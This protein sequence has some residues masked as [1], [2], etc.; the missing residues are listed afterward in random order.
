MKKV[1]VLARHR[2]VYRTCR[3]TT[4]LK[5]THIMALSLSRKMTAAAVTNI[6]I[7]L[8]LAGWSYY[9][10]TE[11]RRL[12]DV[13]AESA[14]QATQLSE[15]AASGAELYRII[16][17][18]EINRD[19]AATAKDWAE[20]KTQV[21]A[22]LAGLAALDASSQDEVRTATEGYHGLVDIFEKQ[23]L[24]QLQQTKDLTE[25]MRDLDGKCDD[26]VSQM[27]DSLE[28]LRDDNVGVAKQA[29]IDFDTRG[30][31][32]TLITIIISVVGVL[33]NAAIFFGLSKL[34]C[35][36]VRQMTS[37]MERLAGG[38]MKTEVPAKQRQDEIGE[39]ATA[40]QIFK[41]N[42]IETERMRG[43]KLAADRLSEEQRRST[44][45][46]LASQFE[47][48]V[49]GVVDTVTTAASQ[50]QSTAQNMSG[51]A[52]RTSQQSSEVASVSASASH[53]IQ[54]VAAATEELSASIHEIS[55][56]V[57]EST[58]IIAVAVNQAGDTNTKMQALNAAAGKIGEVVSLINDIASQTNLL[59]LNATIEAARAGE[60][61]KGFAVVA[62]EVKALANQTAGATEE[63]ANQIRAIQAATENSATAI[64]EISTTIIRVNEISVAIA[65]A[66]EEQGAATQEISRNL[67]EAADGTNHVNSSIGVVTEAS[68]STTA[69]AQEVL[70]AAEQLGRKGQQLQSQVV[71]FLK[72]IRA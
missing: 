27:T 29:D 21:E 17:D 3:V 24:P 49:G 28:K 12:Q 45:L 26:K 67:H 10:T 8:A 4:D 5:D 44:M 7:M 38:D 33:L 55:Q 2:A 15:A 61:G 31:T 40:L 53:N 57:T 13:G 19:L 23:M 66:V 32:T 47:Q 52:Q 70:S 30:Q 34:I 43:E 62:S 36:P 18:A 6:G 37:A 25:A 63:I 22:R 54:T 68:R 56:R 69:M 9:S 42:M 50:L 16:A 65:A 59:A 14:A 58:R 35:A 48:N 60:A 20:K 71:D 51:T 46:N 64:G 1:P 72:T 11:F 39:M 41:D